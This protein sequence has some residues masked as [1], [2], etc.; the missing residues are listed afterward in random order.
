MKILL[1]SPI[2]ADAL[3]ALQ[4][5]HECV[6]AYDA[7]ADVLKEKIQGCDA[8]IFRSGVKITA[9]VMEQS[10]NLRLC[11]RAG[12]GMDNIDVNYVQQHG[13]RVRRIPGP[14]AKAVSEL[15]FALMLGLARNIRAADRKWRAGE[16][17]KHELTG[18]LLTG[19]TLGIVGAGNIGART[20]AMG[21]AWGMKVLG[22]VEH[23]SPRRAEDLAQKGIELVSFEEVLSRSD[24]VSLHVPKT[25]TTANLIDAE[26]LDRMKPGAFLI[27]MARGGVVDEQALVDALERGKLRGAALDVHA[28]EGNGNI[29]PLAR[30][31]NVLLTPHIGAGTFDSQREIG[32]IIVAQVAA[33]T[34]EEALPQSSNG[35][36]LETLIQVVG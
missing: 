2:H 19:K 5:N 28:K 16:W 22:C 29:S 3:H 18:W 31:D 34:Q 17:A 20:G 13:I 21:A 12:S 33:F 4:Q 11:L 32:E 1:A 8:L 9:E 36:T 27:N 23:P 7:P 10:P 15:A 6:L 35:M 14:G 30:F 26:A 24:F 25:S